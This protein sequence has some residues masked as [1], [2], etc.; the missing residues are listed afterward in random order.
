MIR[1]Q[2]LPFRAVLMR[3]MPY[4]TALALG[5]IG[6]GVISAFI[7][8]YYAAQGWSGAWVALS[9]FGVCFVAARVLFVDS[10]ARHGGLKMSLIFFAIETVGQFLIWAVP[11]SWA[12]VAG[13][14]AAGFGFAL[15]FPALG[16]IVV[17]LVP[18]QNRGSAIGAYSMFTDVALCVTGPVAGLLAANVSYASPFLFGAA[19][20]LTAALMMVVLLRGEPDDDRVTQIG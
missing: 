11:H 1:A 4:G 5:A 3:V 19:A 15:I 14:G 6:F 20:S 9:V 2:R 12:A 7:A 17:D 18:A 8:L 10:I 13:A 16:L